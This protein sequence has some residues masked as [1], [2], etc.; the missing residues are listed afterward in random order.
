M[1]LDQLTS[2]DYLYF[3][4]LADSELLDAG[5]VGDFIALCE[6]FVQHQDAQRFIS[7]IM[8]AAPIELRDAREI[9]DA[10]KANVLS[11]QQP[12]LGNLAPSS[13]QGTPQVR[14]PAQSG[15]VRIPGQQ[16]RPA[17]SPSASTPTAAPKITS[18]IQQ[19]APMPPQHARELP[20]IP[21]GFT[22]FGPLNLKQSEP[23]QQAQPQISVYSQ[24]NISAP[25]AAVFPSNQTG[26]N[27]VSNTIQNKEQGTQPQTPKSYDKGKDPYRETF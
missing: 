27:G 23:V 21:V 2:D 8:I 10:I 14:I 22:A 15:Q 3:E 16:Q 17:F 11:V 19:P 26:Q 25:S 6:G 20:K 1:T 4:A 5:E 12:V 9:A 18:P 7:D 24:K 13:A